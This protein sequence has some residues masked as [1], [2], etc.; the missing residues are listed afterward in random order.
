MSEAATGSGQRD[1]SAAMRLASSLQARRQAKG[2][3]GWL[4]EAWME[5]IGMRHGRNFIGRQRGEEQRKGTG[6]KRYRA[7]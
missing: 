5:H 1:A 3:D 6:L 7:P 2:C 4:T